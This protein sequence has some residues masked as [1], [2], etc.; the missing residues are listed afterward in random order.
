MD[1]QNFRD[2]SGLGALFLYIF[3]NMQKIRNILAVCK[4]ILQWIY[5]AIQ[6]LIWQI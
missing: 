2:V 6:E 3:L 4:N 1:T 5:K